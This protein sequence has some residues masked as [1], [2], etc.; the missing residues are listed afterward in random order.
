MYINLIS[1][2]LNFI[3]NMH[4]HWYITRINALIKNLSVQTEDV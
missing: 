3:I 1:I 2:T 4:I